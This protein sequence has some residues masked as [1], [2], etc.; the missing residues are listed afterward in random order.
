MFP[1]VQDWVSDWVTF[2][3]VPSLPVIRFLSTP[4]RTEGASW[5]KTEN[6]LPSGAPAGARP[7]AARI[8]AARKFICLSRLYRSM[9]EQSEDGLA[10]AAPA[11][12]LPTRAA[13]TTPVSARQRIASLTARGDAED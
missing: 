13:T 6:E 3:Y 8:C 9:L 4:P 10:D 7:H 5:L 1:F 12:M 2:G 11:P